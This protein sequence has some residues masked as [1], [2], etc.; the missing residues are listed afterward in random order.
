[1]TVTIAKENY[2][3]SKQLSELSSQGFDLQPHTWDHHMVT[4]YETE[5]VYQRQLVEPRAT[6]EAML[7]KETPFF[8]YPFGIYD[9]KA[10]QKLEN[11]GYKG[12]FR[13]NEMMDRNVKPQ[14]AIKRYIANS[15]WDLELFKTVVRGGWE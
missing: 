13:L 8:A 6:L 10:G 7:G 12:A 1:M 15:Y 9:A 14:F 3:T 4:Q 5:E 2:M 11:L